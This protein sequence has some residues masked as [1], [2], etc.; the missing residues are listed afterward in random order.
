METRLEIKLLGPPIIILDGHVLPPMRSRAAEALLYFLVC[1]PGIHRR[2]LLAEMLWFER[3]PKQ[4]MANFRTALNLLKNTVGAEFLMSNRQTIAFDANQSFKLDLDHFA[5]QPDLI[6]G[7]LLEGFYL[8]EG[9]GFEEWLA[10]EREHIRQRTRASLLASVEQYREANKYHKA[11]HLAQQ[12]VNLDPYDEHAQPLQI[13]LL[14]RTGQRSAALRAYQNLNERLL[15][16]LEAE[17]FKSTRSMV[18]RLRG[19]DY[20]PPSMLPSQSSP[21]IGRSDEIRQLSSLAVDRQSRLIT[22]FGPGGMGKSRFA[23]E[24]VRQIY[25]AIPGRYLN[26]VYFVP[27]VPVT[28]LNELA[29][30]IAETIGIVFQGQSQLFSQLSESLKDWECLIVLDNF[31]QLINAESG[32]ATDKIAEFIEACP[33]LKLMVTSRERLNLYEE[34]VIDLHGLAIPDSGEEAAE[35]DDAVGL[36][37]QTARRFSQDFDPGPEELAEILHTCRLVQGMPLAIELAANWLRLY[38]V[39][40]IR[41][42]IEKSVDFLQAQLRNVPERQ[43]SIRAVFETSWD[44]LSEAEQAIYRQLTLFEGG[45]TLTAAQAVLD[46]GSIAVPQKASF[47]RNHIQALADKSLLAMDR[48]HRFDIH[49]LLRQFTVEMQSAAAPTSAALDGQHRRYFLELL[50][51]VEPHLGDQHAIILAD[52]GNIRKAWL[53]AARTH[54]FAALEQA[55]S[56]LH[57][58]FSLQSWFVQGVETFETALEQLPDVEQ[59]SSQFASAILEIVGRKARMHLHLGQVD[60]AKAELSQVDGLLAAVDS[61]DRRAAIRG[62]QAILNFYAGDYSEAARLGQIGLDLSV[63]SGVPDAKAFAHNFLGSVYKAQGEYAQAANHFREAVDLY[64][65]HDDPV[66][67]AMAL[68]NLGNLTLLED[69]LDRAQAYYEESS[70]LFKLEN[71]VHGA[72]T[73]LAN[74]GKLALKVNRPEAALELLE[75]SLTLKQDIQDLR[76]I[77]VSLGGLAEVAS[78]NQ[79]LRQA[80]AYYREAVGKA[81]EC[82]DKGLAVEL[83]L[84]VAQLRV[85]QS[86]HQAAASLFTFLKAHPAATEDVRAACDAGLAAEGMGTTTPNQPVELEAVVRE[87]VDSAVKFQRP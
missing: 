22:I 59:I 17:P 14:A 58:F 49:P 63:E 62:Y 24:T 81:W 66:G 15:A 35:S 4:A 18:R 21:F 31:E 20:P 13:E 2:D 73:T 74:A 52:I 87:L 85:V 68:N 76:G 11:L 51:Q 38:P 19:L 5:Q 43:S 61:A 3:P 25:S 1:S 12:A 77:A 86:Q 80:E 28:G 41:T 57:S 27:L 30:A 29:V 54:D 48:G 82:G 23:I 65:N 39:V 56:P 40:E 32:R 83:L 50:G 45:F 72:A 7:T 70:H 44:L 16:D 53:G 55:A 67:A 34:V 9:R 78:F 84:G 37:V 46:S 10:V 42:Q 36:F 26:G 33:D 8:P 6:R 71:H 60:D 64:K 69:K 47:I 75:E 79:D